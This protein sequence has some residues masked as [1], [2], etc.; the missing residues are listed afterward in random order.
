MLVTSQVSVLDEE[1]AEIRLNPE[2]RKISDISFSRRDLRFKCQRCAV[3]CCKLGG[4]R[5]SEV[6]TER[7]R[8]AGCEPTDFLDMATDRRSELENAGGFAMKQKEDGSCIFLECDDSGRNYSCSVYESRPALCR[9][10]PFE[11]KRTGLSTV[12]LRAIPCCNGL[13]ACDGALVDRGFVEERLLG[14]ISD[15]F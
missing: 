8:R 6:D 9:L 4:P 15:L 11:I 13:N 3:F 7:L 14:L 5:L 12:L 2:T 10:Y 1:I